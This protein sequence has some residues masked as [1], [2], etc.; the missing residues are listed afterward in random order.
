MMEGTC[1]KII[2]VCSVIHLW[3][4]DIQVN[5]KQLLFLS[6]QVCPVSICNHIHIAFG[7]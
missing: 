7:C 6:Y 4:T 3:E 1:S 5:I 2:K